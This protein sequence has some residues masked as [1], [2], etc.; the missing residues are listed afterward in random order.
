MNP[1]GDLSDLGIS[2]EGDRRRGTAGAQR[3]AE[4][5]VATRLVLAALT[6]AMVCATVARVQAQATSAGPSLVTHREQW[7]AAMNEWP[8]DRLKTYF[9]LCDLESRMHWMGL[10][11][12]ARCAMAW[13]AL[14]KRCFSG[15]VEAMLAWWRFHR[16]QREPRPAGQ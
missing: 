2:S 14:L 3:V 1:T 15:D 5:Q 12:G 4:P 7:L 16:L 6:L 9:L 11:D 10:D 13:D 8:L